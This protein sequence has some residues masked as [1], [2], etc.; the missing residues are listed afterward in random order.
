MAGVAC[1]RGGVAGALSGRPLGMAFPLSSKRFTTLMAG[2]QAVAETAAMIGLGR[3]GFAAQRTRLAE[4]D[5]A[6]D[7]EGAAAHA[8]LV[9]AAVQDRLQ[10]NVRVA[11]ADVQRANALRP[12]KLVGRETEQVGSE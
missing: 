11:A 4:A 7:G 5:D 12:V 10:P 2:R 9:A 3:E 8:A 1:S 6:G